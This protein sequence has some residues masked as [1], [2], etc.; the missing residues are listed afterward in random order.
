[1]EKHK[2][3][4]GTFYNKCLTVNPDTNVVETL[5]NLLAANFVSYGSADSKSKEQLIGQISYF[6]RLIPDLRWEIQEIIHEDNKYVVRSVASGTPNGD[7]MGLPTNGS[8]SFRIMT[9]DIH[10]IFEGKLTNVHHVEDW[11]TAMK[12][13]KS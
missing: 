2:E 5:D 3:V 10:T 1:M 8:K 7:F 9:I 11:P 4:L 13:L 12:Q 6:W